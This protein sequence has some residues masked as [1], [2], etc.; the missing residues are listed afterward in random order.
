MTATTAILIRPSGSTTVRTFGSDEEAAKILR[1][2][3][4][5][6]VVITGGPS[7][8]TGCE[9][10]LLLGRSADSPGREKFDLN[11]IATAL[12]GEKLYGPALLVGEEEGDTESVKGASDT[13]EFIRRALRWV[14]IDGNNDSAAVHDLMGQAVELLG[15]WRRD[16][17]AAETLNAA[18]RGGRHV[19][20]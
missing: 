2:H 17:L 1:G 3:Q 19:F 14:C 16:V 13:A 11:P 15:A 20:A 12:C 5:D 9:G 8:L 4:S 10:S 18:T 7:E 6:L